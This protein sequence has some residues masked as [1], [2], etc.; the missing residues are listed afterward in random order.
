MAK[1]PLHL[2]ADASIKAVYNALRERGHDVTRTPND[3]V[4][5]DADDRAQLLGA[6]AQG[7]ILFTF[8]IRD[9]QVLAKQYSTHQGI[10]LAVQSRWTISELIQSLDRALTQTD[11][12]DCL[13]V[14]RW[15][16]DFKE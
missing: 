14:V 8:N 11:D 3:W 1:P 4:L 10:L 5:S 2:D 7:R 12:K 13:G 6:T 16:N 9:F 15:L